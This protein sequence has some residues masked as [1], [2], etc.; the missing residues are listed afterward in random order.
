M[1]LGV[2]VFVVVAVVVVVVVV[3]L[4]LVVV[5]VKK[6]LLNSKLE[7]TGFFNSN[8]FSRYFSTLHPVPR[9]ASRCSTRFRT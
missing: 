3:I 2:A 7:K 6:I 9:F 5:S 8:F 4:L 1:A